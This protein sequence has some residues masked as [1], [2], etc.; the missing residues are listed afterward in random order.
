MGFVVKVPG[1]GGKV[2]WYVKY[3]D[4]DGAW[5]QRASGQPTKELTKKLLSEIEARVGRGLVG[6]VERV[7]PEPAL[8]LGD[9]I[10]RFLRDYARPRLKDAE[11][12]RAAAKVEL[13]RLPEDWRRRPAA[14]ITQ[15]DGLLQGQCGEMVE[16]AFDTAGLG[17]IDEAD[18]ALAHA[19]VGEVGVDVAMRAAGAAGVEDE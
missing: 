18:E 19:P 10:D 1:A 2:R 13:G 15:E 16:G 4:L 17:G 14:G 5:K 7:K 9:L 3:R 12:Y 11:G 6:M 8:L